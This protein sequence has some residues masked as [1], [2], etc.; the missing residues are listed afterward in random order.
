MR[1]RCWTADRLEKRGLPHPDACSLCD[2]QQETI[3]YLLTSCIFTRQFW[4]S[5]L[6]P[7]SL[8]HLT[9]AV[10][11]PSFAEWWR[12]LV[13]RGHKSRKKGLN[14]VIILGAWC[15]WLHRNKVIFNV[16]SPSLARLQRSFL[17]EL[18]CW[19][20]AGAKN[21]G[22]LDLARAPNVVGS[23]S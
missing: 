20:M 18:V 7:F 14:S 4:F 12:R 22:S 10:D 9:P 21:L 6:S 3:Q 8:G 13:I 19:V 2:Q 5:I 17:D 15:V 16:E 11:E 23:A 1:N